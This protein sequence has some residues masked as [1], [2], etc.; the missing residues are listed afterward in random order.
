MQLREENKRKETTLWKK[1]WRE[2][3]INCRDVFV[4]SE[5]KVETK[6]KIT[7]E[8]QL[9]REEKNAIELIERQDKIT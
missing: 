2:D 6:R 9:Q 3:K 5:E 4:S 8:L 1:D 7:I